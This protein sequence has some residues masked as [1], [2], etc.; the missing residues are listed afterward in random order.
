MA[1]AVKAAI[2][3]SVEIAFV[4]QGHA[5]ERPAVAAAEHGIKPAVVK[6]PEAKR[7]FVPLPPRQRL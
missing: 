2:D 3:E 7:G 1:E 4:D 6:L 5:G